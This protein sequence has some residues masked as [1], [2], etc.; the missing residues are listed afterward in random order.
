M[1]AAP[2]LIRID[3]PTG[4][5]L[6]DDCTFEFQYNSNIPLDVIA[7]VD[8]WLDIDNGS[9]IGSV[10]GALDLIEWNNGTAKINIESAI[11]A[12]CAECGKSGD[13]N[14]KC[15]IKFIA[16]KDSGYADSDF[17][18][19]SNSIVYSTLIDVKTITLSPSN[20]L[21]CQGKT[22]SIGKTVSPI[23]AYYE[24]IIWSSGDNS[25]AAVDQQ[26]NITGIKAG[27]TYITAT[28]GGIST[29]VPVTVYT[30]SSN[31][32]DTQ[33]NIAVTN[34]A[35]DIIDGIIYDDNP[36]LDNT[37]I[38]PDDINDIKEDIVEAITDGDSFHTDIVAIQQTFDL[39]SKNWE[40]V[41]Q[42]VGDLNAQFE[43]AYNIE[44][45]MYH[46]DEDGSETHIGNIIEFENEITFTFELPAGMK[47]K[48]SDSIIGFVLVRVHVTSDGTVEYNSIDYTINNDGTF[49]AASDKYSYFIWVSVSETNHSDSN[50]SNDYQTPSSLPSTGEKSSSLSHIGLILLFM[51][52]GGLAT[53]KNRKPENTTHFG[54]RLTR[55]KK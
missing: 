9:C 19:Y 24:T 7:G 42:T 47:E 50:I 15:I 22:I 29:T 13:V 23:N 53:I 4:L 44:V 28:I 40:Q 26:G 35:S 48:N 25:I 17:S 3:T 45:E 16:I 52:I 8:I 37:D 18:S 38:N 30:I 34:T 2:N 11:L 36:V 32:N 12:G 6:N 39:N 51:S 41:Q 1:Y 10:P 31:V 54:V 49:T 20:P 21:L 27:S 14:V 5:R 43:G 33:E 55:H 46:Q